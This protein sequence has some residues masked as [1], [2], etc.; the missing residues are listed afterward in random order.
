MQPPKIRQ[1][2]DDPSGG[3]EFRL[4]GSELFM[5][6]LY[7]KEPIDAGGTDCDLFV[8][9]L[10]KSKVDALYGEPAE[11]VWDGPYK[12]RAQVEWP[13][14]TPEVTEAGLRAIWPSGVWIPRKTVEE[15]GARAPREGDI[16]RFWKLPFFDHRAGNDQPDTGAGFFFDVIKVSD[17]GHLHDDAA[18]VGFRCDLKRRSDAPPEVNFHPAKADTD[19]C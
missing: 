6:D 3:G 18:F 19:D 15:A 5:H 12:V 8:R 16:V 9:D 4:D 10:K 13:E 11:T 14:F 2:S 17:D 7:A 1:P